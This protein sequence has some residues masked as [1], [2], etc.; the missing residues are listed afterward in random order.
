M[1]KLIININDYKS[2][3]KANIEINKLNVVSGVNGSGKSTVGRIFY[4][5]LKGN[6]TKRKN[7]FIKRISVEFNKI[8]DRLD[9]DVFDYNLPDYFE[10]TDT[11]EE[12]DVKYNSTYEITGKHK[13][14]CKIKIEQLSNQI[15]K[16][17]K[18]FLEKLEKEEHINSGDINIDEIE[19]GKPDVFQGK[20]INFPEELPH[21]EEIFGQDIAERYSEDIEKIMKLYYDRLSCYLTQDIHDECNSNSQLLKLYLGE[22]SYEVSEECV[23]SILINEQYGVINK[24]NLNF[25][26]ELSNHSKVNVYEY[27]FNQ[28]F[29]DNIYYFD[30]VS[31]FDFYLLN[32]KQNIVLSHNDEFMDELFDREARGNYCD[33][34]NPYESY[35]DH[36]KSIL[37]KIEDIIGG[38]YSAPFAPLF[39]TG[40]TENIVESENSTFKKQVFTLSDTPSGI[41]QMGVIQVLLLNNKLKKG[42][43]L[44]IDEP[45]INLHPDW[46]FKFAEILVLLAKLDIIIYINSHSP[47][48]IEAITAFCEFYDMED[49]VNYYLTESSEVEGKYDFVKIRSD[50]RFRVYDNLGNAYDL[51]DQLRLKKRFGE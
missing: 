39:F 34:V 23:Q 8:I 21:I 12:L 7:Y 45:E 28:G 30:N 51:I 50:E 15:S 4:S 11:E 40:K 13:N 18:L 36:I 25:E 6:S 35:D 20:R 19:S 22:D 9:S 41:K 1:D 10:A 37:E 46:Q 26:M 48:F 16:D 31:I 44:I 47:L 29:I 24:E 43:Y 42:D 27:F 32:S 3:N 33:A 49:D 14:L 17:L 5:F 38:I 2:I